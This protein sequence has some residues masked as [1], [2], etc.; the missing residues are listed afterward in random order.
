MDTQRGRL[1]M[2]R[3]EV[4]FPRSRTGRIATGGLLIAGGCLGFLPV[5]GFWM[6]PLGVIVLS[7]DLHSVRRFRRRTSVKWKRWRKGREGAQAK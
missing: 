2:G 6:V 7:H 5:L 1:V 3:V 4:P